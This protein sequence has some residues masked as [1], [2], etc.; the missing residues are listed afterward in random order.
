MTALFF[1]SRTPKA[2]RAAVLAAIGA[3][4]VGGGVLLAATV[5]VGATKKISGRA[6]VL[7]TDTGTSRITADVT[8]TAPTELVLIGATATLK[9]SASAKIIQHTGQTDLGGKQAAPK[10]TR[11]KLAKAAPGSEIVFSGRYSSGTT[12]SVTAITIPDRA[13]TVC[14]TFKS[15]TRR[16]AAGANLD[17]LTVEPKQVTVQESRYSRLFPKEKDVVFAFHGSTKFWNA[18]GSWKN[19]KNRRQMQIDDVSALNQNVRVQGKVTKENVLE[20]E[21]VDLD[22]KCS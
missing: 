15:I 17:T 5:A 3:A 9:V 10:T 16:T 8:T 21:T 14:G 6:I 11:V 22:I 12:V 13:F 19:P 7:S 2:A 20:V 18:G 1:S 4:V